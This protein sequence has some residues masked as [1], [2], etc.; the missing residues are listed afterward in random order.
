MRL[1]FT[2]YI[3]PF[4]FVYNAALLFHGSAGDVLFM[5]ITAAIGIIYLAFAF[6]GYLWGVGILPLLARILLGIGGLLTA[7]PDLATTLIGIGIL[8]VMHAICFVLARRK[9]VADTK[10]KV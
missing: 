6:E 4:F 7:F 10:S 5:S 2:K 8:A 3:V 9:T 1:G